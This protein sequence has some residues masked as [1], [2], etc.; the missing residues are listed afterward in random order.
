MS[1]PSPSWFLQEETDFLNQAPA[2][3]ELPASK[4]GRSSSTPGG[5][6]ERSGHAHLRYPRNKPPCAG[7][8][9]PAG[10]RDGEGQRVSR[11][12]SWYSACIRMTQVTVTTA[13]S[14]AGAC[15]EMRRKATTPWGDDIDSTPPPSYAEA[16]K[17][18]LNEAAMFILADRVGGGPEISLKEVC[19]Q[20]R[21]HGVWLVVLPLFFLLFTFWRRR[22]WTAKVGAGIADRTSVAEWSPVAPDRTR[23]DLSL[24]SSRQREG[25]GVG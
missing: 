12:T 22:C 4:T 23:K 20:T 1:R 3:E 18:C 9:H 19:T 21:A 8:E 2:R 10:P 16:G 6:R 25:R 14:N 11:V 5:P 13:A 15:R 7:A 24:L 17:P